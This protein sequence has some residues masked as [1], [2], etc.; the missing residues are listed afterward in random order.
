MFPVQVTLSAEVFFL[1]CINNKEEN[2]PSELFVRDSETFH[3]NNNNSSISPDPPA[4]RRQRIRFQTWSG[5]PM[6][7]SPP[8]HS[9]T[10]SIIYSGQPVVSGGYSGRPISHRGRLMNRPDPVLHQTPGELQPGPIPLHVFH[11]RPP[12]VGHLS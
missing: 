11:G 3:P 10:S 5:A 6:I 7:R 9:L 4:A 12:S 8:P 1:L 2:F